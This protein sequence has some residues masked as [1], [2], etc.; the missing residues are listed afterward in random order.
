MEYIQRTCEYCK[1]EF[2]IKKFRI[3]HGRG[4]CCS[5]ECRFKQ[6]SLLL[7]GRYPK[8]GISYKG[9]YRL[10]HKPEHPHAK[11][12]GYIFEHRLVVEK[13]IGRILKPEE[14]IH[15]LNGDKLDNRFENLEIITQSEHTHKHKRDSK[16]RFLHHEP[17]S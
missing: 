6:H 8:G 17:I 5:K 1:K 11:D 15:H 12:N 10:I 9:G 7:K 4:K 16:G 14:K 3:A 2:S 13:N